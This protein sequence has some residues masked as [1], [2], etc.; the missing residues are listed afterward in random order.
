MSWF[1]VVLVALV[2]AAGGVA[3]ALAL[4]ARVRRDF[5]SSNQVVPGVP[6]RAP[7][8][9]AGAHHLPARLHRRL[10]DAMAALRANQDFD[11]DGGMLDLRVELEQQALALDDR[12]VAAAALAPELQHEPLAQAAESVSTIEQTVAALAGRSAA[13]A[14]AALQQA[15][16]RARERSD[17]LAQIQAELDQLPAE[18]PRPTGEPG[19]QPGPGTGPGSGPSPA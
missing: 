19:T 4:A 7:D 3:G 11:D 12:I 15:L 14:Q 8:S 9:W 10:R 6:T 1:V 16:E 5:A 2:V 17:L 13:Q 18:P